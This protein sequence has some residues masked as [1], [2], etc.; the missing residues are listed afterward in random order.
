MTA[1]AI[2]VDVGGTE[3]KAALVTVDRDTAR[4][5]RHARRPTPRGA[6]G[7]ATADLVVEAVAEVVSDL[8]SGAD[9][10]DAVGVVVPGVVDEVRGD[11]KSVV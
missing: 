9:V 7:A 6:D 3:M 5:L 8:R 4:P 10:V 11:R 2:A 1:H